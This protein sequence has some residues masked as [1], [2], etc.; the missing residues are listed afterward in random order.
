MKCF[1]IAVKTVLGICLVYFKL[2][3]MVA[4]AIAVVRERVIPYAAVDTITQG[5]IFSRRQDLKQST[6]NLQFV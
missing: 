3:P 5:S 2:L 4:S 6:I 1:N